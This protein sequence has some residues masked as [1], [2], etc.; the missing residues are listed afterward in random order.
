[1]RKHRLTFKKVQGQI[2]A[3]LVTVLTLAKIDIQS[4]FKKTTM[5]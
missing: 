2:S 4:I 5:K 1:M 3:K